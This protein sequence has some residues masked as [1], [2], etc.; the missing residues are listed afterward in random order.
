MKHASLAA[1]SAALLATPLAAHDGAHADGHA[2]IGVMADHTHSAGEVMFSYR[3]MHMDMGGNRIGTDTVTPDEIVTTVPNRFFGNPGQ[4]PTLRIVPTEMRMD[5]HM[6]G[7]MYAPTD[8]VTLIAMGSYI[9]KEM[10]HITYQGG[11]GTTQLGGFTTRPEGIGDI[12]VGGLFPITKAHR[13]YE[14]LARA[15]V[16]I[17]VGST[18]E[19]DDILTP[20]GGTPT[21]RL[22]YSMQIGSGTWDLKPALTYRGYADEANIGWGL[23][24]NGTIRLG[25]NDNGFAYGDVHEVTGW[26]SYEP[27]YWI[28]FSGRLAA[29]TTGRVDGI[30]PMIMG[31]VQT[32]NP[33]FQGGGRIDAFVGVNL[34]AQGG[35]EGQ[36]LAIEVGTPI[37]QDLN[38]PQMDTNWTLTLG[39]Q[40][41][42]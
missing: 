26:V 38:G 42:F 25:E 31:P 20:T 23:Q 10:E 18:T 12:T 17:P 41:T 2:P 35:L 13:R 8:W 40:G 14:V 28:S 21:I 34:A 6:I 33:D 9:S 29:R 3:F 27:A 19:T 39:W 15:A 37:Y 22:P 36:R 32:A 4:P 24:Y 1:L 7:A 30:D 5:M 11:M 16:S